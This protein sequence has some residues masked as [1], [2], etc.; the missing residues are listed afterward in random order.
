MEPK[1]T[2]HPDRRRFCGGLAHLFL[3][4][5]VALLTGAALALGQTPTKVP[6]TLAHQSEQTRAAPAGETRRIAIVLAREQRDLSPPIS[7]LDVRPPDDGIAGARLAINDNNTTGRFLGQ[8]FT[9]TVVQNS[10]AAELIADAK[11]QVDAGAS[12]IIADASAQTLLALA[13]A[14]KGRDALILNAGAS[15]DRLREQDCRPNVVHTAPSRA[16]LADALAQYLRWKRWQ[17]WF[18][19]YG[20]EPGDEAFADALRRSAKRFGLKIVEER[21]F[22]DDVGSRA[23]GGHE[24]IQER[25]PAFTQRASA[26]DV[27]LVADE[28]GRFG[29]YFPYRTFDPRPVAG[30]QGLVPT[31]WHPALEQ[32]GA[33]Q[34]QNRFRRLANRPMESLDYDA[35]V[36]V[37][38][39]GEAATRSK[40]ASPADLISYLKSPGFELGAFKGRKLTFR[41]WDGQL[42]QPILIGTAKLPVSVSP[43]PGFLHQFTELDTL[44]FDKPET[45]CRA[46]GP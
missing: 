22:K 9:L 31:S 2:P 12:F 10:N 5:A 17:R 19:V 27:L 29:E 36:A 25:I 4:A 45:N 28:S 1:T 8:E 40:T 42:R 7:P 32:W 14:M 6:T 26:H 23:D 30:T 33:T 43:Q 34:I 39:I 41:D 44:G 37:R 21:Q 20:T 3:A 38:A 15:D 24:Q 11:T 35:W 46:Y 18:L 16:M 13:D